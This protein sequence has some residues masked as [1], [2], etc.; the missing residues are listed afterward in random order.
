MRKNQ[1]K[2]SFLAL[3]LGG[4]CLQAQEQSTTAGA[5]VKPTS[6]YNYHDAFAPNFYTKNGTDTH[7]ASGQP[8]A[9]YWQNKADYQLTATLNEKNNEIIATEIL[10]Y[11]NN[12]PDKILFYG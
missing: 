4:M 12:S 8:G 11:T 5:N 1:F 2:A 9:K 10:T 6:K 3:V 7:S